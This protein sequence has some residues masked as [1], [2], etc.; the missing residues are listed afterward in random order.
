M[1]HRLAEM[2]DEDPREQH[3]RR[4]EPDAAKLQAPERHA[5]H[6]NAREHGD[7]MRDRLRLVELLEPGHLVTRRARRL[8]KGSSLHRAFACTTSLV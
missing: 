1:I 4:A 3:A 6:A 2:P 5:E 8:P 7:R